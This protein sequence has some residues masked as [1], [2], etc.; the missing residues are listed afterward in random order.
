MPLSVISGKVVHPWGPRPLF[1]TE[2]DLVVLVTLPQ[3][4]Y[5]VIFPHVNYGDNRYFS[6]FHVVSQIFFKIKFFNLQMRGLV[7]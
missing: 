1:E 2:D 4:H 5:D 6:S 3:L 7:E